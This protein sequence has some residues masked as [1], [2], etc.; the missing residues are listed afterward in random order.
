MSAFFCLSRDVL[1]QYRSTKLSLSR[2]QHFPLPV[3]GVAKLG[4]MGER[5]GEAD[6]RPTLL[7][8]NLHKANE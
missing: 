3:L 5:V 1:A 2:C 7:C 8:G 4:G 6:N